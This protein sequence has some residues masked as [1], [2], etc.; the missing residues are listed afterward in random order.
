MLA[1]AAFI[2]VMIVMLT[3]KR[4]CPAYK[5]LFLEKEY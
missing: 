5:N 4:Q 2:D 1:Y 3:E